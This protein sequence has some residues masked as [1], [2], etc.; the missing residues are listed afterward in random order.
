M[1]VRVVRSHVQTDNRT[2]GTG[3]VIEL[4][5]MLADLIQ[6]KKNKD[7]KKINEIR[8]R[9]PEFEKM[10]VLIHSLSDQTEIDRLKIDITNELS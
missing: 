10:D 8:E 9:F 2:M 3:Q 4:E 5:N 6:A 1:G 7:A